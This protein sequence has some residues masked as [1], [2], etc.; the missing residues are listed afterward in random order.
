MLWYYNYVLVL[1][2]PCLWPSSSS[3]L[4]SIL[5]KSISSLT[6][7]FFHLPF[8]HFCGKKALCGFKSME[9]IPSSD[10]TV[11]HDQ[12]NINSD[13][14][15]CHD[16]RIRTRWEF[17]S[18]RKKCETPQY[19]NT[20]HALCWASAWKRVGTTVVFSLPVLMVAQVPSLV[21]ARSNIIF[22]C[23]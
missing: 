12:D 8:S 17:L 18:T 20:S 5:N 19:F 11:T 2:I 3:Q 21:C 15:R 9:R 16:R 1:R 23:C 4:S 13:M 7:Y 10:S 14:R 6:K 22:V